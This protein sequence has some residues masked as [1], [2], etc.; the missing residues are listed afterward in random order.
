[1]LELPVGS[2]KKH[3]LAVGG[4]VEFGLQ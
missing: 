3:K 2:I 4:T 1:V